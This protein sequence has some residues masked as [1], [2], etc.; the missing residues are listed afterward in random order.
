[1]VVIRETLQDFLSTESDHIPRTSEAKQ[2][3]VEEV[4]VKAINI[5][6]Q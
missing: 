6:E 1:M 4:R 2:E 5:I 3:V